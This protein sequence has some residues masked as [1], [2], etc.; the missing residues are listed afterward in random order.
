MN[1]KSAMLVLKQLMKHLQNWRTSK[2]W[3]VFVRRDLLKP[4]YPVFSYLG[5]TSTVALSFLLTIRVEQAVSA[6][7]FTIPPLDTEMLNGTFELFEKGYI[8]PVSNLI[9]QLRTI[10]LNQYK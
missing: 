3:T 5:L 6:F 9:Q 1:S 7:S 10:L 8:N 4:T 2:G